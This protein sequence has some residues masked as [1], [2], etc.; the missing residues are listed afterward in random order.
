MDAPSLHSGGEWP[1]RAPLRTR[2]ACTQPLQPGPPGRRAQS[3]HSGRVA[4]ES[5]WRRWQR[6]KSSW[7]PVR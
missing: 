2:S 4:Y 1:Q 5:K 7:Y 6:V 3:A